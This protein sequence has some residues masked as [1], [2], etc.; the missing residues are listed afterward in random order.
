VIGDGIFKPKNQGNY[1]STDEFRVDLSTNTVTV[2]ACQDPSTLSSKPY[3]TIVFGVIKL[4]DYMVKIR[5][6]LIKAYADSLMT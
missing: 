4:P 3:G 1:L 6:L 5:P 2:S